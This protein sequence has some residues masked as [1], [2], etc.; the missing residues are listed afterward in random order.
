LT[1]TAENVSLIVALGQ[2]LLYGC[3]ANNVDLE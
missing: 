1:S 3:R 2:I